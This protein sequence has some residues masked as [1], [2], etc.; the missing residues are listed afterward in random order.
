MQVDFEHWPY[1][2]LVAHRWAGKLAPENTLAAFRVGAGFGYRMFEF[3]VKL[4]RDGVP[5]LLHDADLDRTTNG[6][7]PAGEQDWSAL[8]DRDA[9]GWHGASWTGEPL[10]RL[11]AIVAYLRANRFLADVEIKPSPGREIET[12]RSV[13]L[14]CA[15]AWQGAEVPPILTSFSE[16]ALAAAAEAVPG[17]P[18]G[19]LFDRLPPDWPDRLRRHGAVALASNHRELDREI[20]A[21][22]HAERFRVLCYTPNEPERVA[23]LFAF[24]VDCVITDAVDRIPVK[25]ETT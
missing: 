10:P 2:R 16:V 13:A 4:S 23:E 15:E 9:G 24:G 17:L 21:R 20:V 1:P 18:R 19:L 3:D 7:G 5:F 11:S 14:A 25:S 6:R 22:A 8:A 12:G